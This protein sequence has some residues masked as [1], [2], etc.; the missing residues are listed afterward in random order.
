METHAA[1]STSPSTMSAR[2][3]LSSAF[4]I[5]LMACGTAA[6][7]GFRGD[8][9]D[10]GAEDA[11]PDPAF[12]ESSATRADGSAVLRGIVHAPQPKISIS[13]A[14]VYLTDQRPDAIS[15][16]VFCDRCVRLVDGTPFTLSNAKGE[17]SLAASKLGKQYLVVQKGGFRRVRSIDVKEGQQ[18]LAAALTT[19]PARADTANGDDVPRM[20]IVKGSSD[21]IEE[22]LVKL[23]VAR[24]AL[25]MT[26]AA[27]LRDAAQLKRFHILFLPCG[28]DA[29]ASKD[30]TVQKNLRD[31]AAAGGRVY[32]TDWHYDFVHQ[33]WPGYVQFKGQ[34]AAPCSGCS[35]LV[36]DAPATVNDDGM[37]KWLAANGAANVRLEAN[38]VTISSVGQVQS[39][40]AAGA[41]V[42]VKP[43]VWVTGQTPD[44]ARPATVSFERACGRVLFSTYHTEPSTDPSLKAQELALLYV[45]LEVSVCNESPTGTVPG[46]R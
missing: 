43:K 6:P 28:D 38:Y 4:G 1:R 7:A 39:T 29:T 37:D 17:F 18:N 10:D 36:Y 40:D 15:P 33:V 12:A 31:F 21:P 22:S 14:L 20:A 46:P 45:L 3:T 42:T 16:A 2:R 32:A 41:S 24:E 25:T 11:D 19:L 44:G 9:I 23:G 35:D 34:S 5:L 27:I 8:R 26:S 30:P 13:G